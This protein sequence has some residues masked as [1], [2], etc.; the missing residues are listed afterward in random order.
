M[1]QTMQQQYLQQ[2]QQFQQQLTA[3]NPQGAAQS[4]ACVRP[5]QPNPVMAGGESGSF[6][7]PPAEASVSSGPVAGAAATATAMPEPKESIQQDAPAKATVQ[8]TPPKAITQEEIF[9]A[10]ASASA[11]SAQSMGSKPQRRQKMSRKAAEMM[12]S[13]DAKAMEADEKAELSSYANGSYAYQYA[14]PQMQQLNPQMHSSVGMS[15]QQMQARDRVLLTSA[16]F[17]PRAV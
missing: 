11:H 17:G 2:L 7:I 9:M 13:A 15:Q 4:I 1:Q 5:Q 14:Q 6:S 12:S 3:G 10:A 16:L 8:D